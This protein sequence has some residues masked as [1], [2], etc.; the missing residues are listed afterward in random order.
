MT[1]TRED[2]LQHPDVQHIPAEW[3]A[4][5]T[6]VEIEAYIA[7]LAAGRIAIAE[8][9]QREAEERRDWR[10]PEWLVGTAEVREGRRTYVT[11]D[12]YRATAGNRSGRG[13]SDKATGWHLRGPGLRET[14]HVESLRRMVEVIEWARNQKE[15]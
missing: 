2:L 13:R 1:K 15:N 14:I 6:D 12:G 7:S 4:D 3:L 5:K 10:K 8:Q 11:E 9:Q